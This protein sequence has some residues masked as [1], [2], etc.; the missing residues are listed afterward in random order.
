MP[1]GKPISL[2]PATAYTTR[3][4]DRG[5]GHGYF[6]Y[7]GRKRLPFRYGSP[8]SPVPETALPL[9]RRYSVALA[10]FL[11]NV[12]FALVLCGALGILLRDL[13]RKD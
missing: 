2:V 5:V 9:T 12:A 11:Y 10:N 3:A 6:W 7:K 8:W 4:Q 13:K 1:K